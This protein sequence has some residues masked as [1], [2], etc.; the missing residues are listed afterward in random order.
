MQNNSNG[1]LAN[2]VVKLEKA[3]ES[4]MMAFESE[5]VRLWK[6]NSRSG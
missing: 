1:A 5:Q 6:V 4:A 2:G 3:F